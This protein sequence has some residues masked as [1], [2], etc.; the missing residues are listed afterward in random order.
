MPAY[1]DHFPCSMPASWF[2][3]SVGGADTGG[4]PCGS[5]ALEPG[6]VEIFQALTIDN[7]SYNI[8]IPA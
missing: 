6:V 7:R 5:R 4:Y 2:V 8:V 1:G 3:C